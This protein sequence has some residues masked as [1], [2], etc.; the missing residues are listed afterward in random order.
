VP[1]ILNSIPSPDLN[2]PIQAVLDNRMSVNTVSR[3][4]GSGT[5]IANCPITGDVKIR[6]TLFTIQDA[7]S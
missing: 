5:T 7:G 4:T 2:S 1:S 6:G 3:D